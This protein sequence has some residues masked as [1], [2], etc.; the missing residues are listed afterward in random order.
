[1][2]V[3]QHQ[4]FEVFPKIVPAGSEQRITI[5]PLGGA[6]PF[7]ERRPWY[8]M[9]VARDEVI[10]RAGEQK[11]GARPAVSVKGGAISFSHRFSGEQE[12][13][14]VLKYADG[15]RTVERSVFN[16]YSLREDLYA[17]WPY[18]GDLHLH[19]THSDGRTPPAFV[20]ARAREIGMDFLALTDHYDYSGSLEAIEAFKGVELN[21]A[22]FPGEEVHPPGNWVH[23]V[24][25]GGSF[26][27]NKLI[28]D[29]E[30]A[31]RAAVAEIEK[32]VAGLDGL[33]RRQ[34]ASCRWVYDRIREGGGLAILCHP[35]WNYW[36]A[37]SVSEAE[38][39]RHFEEWPCDAV[40]LLGGFPQR[41]AEDN[42]LMVAR[43]QEAIARRG[44]RPLGIV[45]ASDA[46]DTDGE[47]FGWFYTIVFSPSASLTDLAASIRG[48]LSVAVEAYPNCPVRVF[49]SFRLV[50]Y[51]YFLLREVFGPHDEL[52]AEEGRLMRLHLSGDSSAAWRLGE[53]AG[54][55][56]WPGL[57]EL[58]R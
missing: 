31:Y 49:G 39:A 43:W 3:F 14:F 9:A 52:C 27:V 46:H 13:R 38:L 7:D 19:S 51:A 26:S 58:S 1:M 48:G 11:V 33:A 12:H 24:N 44:G 50:K 53:L 56:A 45:G 34:Y 36:H 55:H 2:A 35:Y 54:R 30:A 21:A 41:D 15:D 25:F 28:R 42:M 23:M 16:V 5:R 6:A 37:F 32:T 22:L 8:V 4:R 17:R 20:A 40:E 57:P 47:L 18:K 29:D 10:D